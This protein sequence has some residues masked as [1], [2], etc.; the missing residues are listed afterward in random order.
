MME[1]GGEPV[2][3]ERPQTLEEG[4]GEGGSFTRGAGVGTC[5]WRCEPLS[6]HYGE[7]KE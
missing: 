7:P 5:S 3:L 4:G 1:C 2:L 6:D